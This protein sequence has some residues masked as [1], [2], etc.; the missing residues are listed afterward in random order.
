[1]K[2]W[3]LGLT[4]A[5]TLL[6]QQDLPSG[7]NCTFRNDP[8]EYLQRESRERAALFARTGKVAAARF[9]AGEST[10]ER[11]IN[12]RDV[13]RRNFIDVE[14]FDR[15]TK[16]GVAS[17][18]LT[19]DE[20]FVRRIY[21]DLTGRLPG[22]A[23]VKSFAD[24]SAADKRN[25][26]IDRLLYSPAFSERWTMWLGDLLGVTQQTTNVNLQIG[27]RNAMFD[28]L[29]IAV[30]TEK[31]LKDIA[32]A[33]VTGTGNGFSAGAANFVVLG[34]QSMGPNQ[35]WYDLTLYQTADKFLGL[36]HYDCLLCHDGRGHLDE[37]SM[38]GR[39]ATRNEA[40]R[41]AAF[42]SRVSM[43]QPY[44]ND[45]TS[46]LNGSWEVSDLPRGN[47]ALGSTFGNRPN[48]TIVGTQRSLDAEY[49]TGAKPNSENWRVEF[50]ENMVRD[51]LMG[52]NFAN[53]IW[54]AMFN[55][56]LVEPVNGLD[57]ARL[58]PDNPPQTLPWTLQAS[59]PKLLQLLGKELAARDFSLREFVRL[60]A[61]SSAYQLSARFDGEWNV[62]QVPLF[63]RHYP[64][65]LEAEEI[66]DAVAKST[67]VMTNYIPAGWSDT[68]Q[69]AVQLPDTSEP[70]AN[71]AALNFMAPFLRG[72][73]DAITRNQAGSI[74]QQL[75][76]MNNTFVTA[77]TKMNASPTLKAVAAIADNGGAVEELYLTVLA[78]R[79][80]AYEKSQAAAH[81]AKAPGRNAALEDLAWAL[82]NK[83]EFLFSY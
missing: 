62:S 83:A 38:W 59:H 5:G 27:G 12:A 30:A 10:P 60:I 47:Y 40:Q 79:P 1:M 16:E 14:I 76:L 36:S 69:W 6:A 35:D 51:P 7:E 46:P 48:R 73:R 18:R 55:Y 17:A 72:N 45:R 24:D 80:S 15:L 50:A 68:V 26:L 64:R 67:G 42:F 31:S 58:D 49:R 70:R 22:A 82:I 32:Y 39:R 37:L 44:N 54:R 65:R 75:N 43:A 2:V 71:G 33:A 81:F 34:R 21:L 8:D 41:M 63:A 66:H 61:E 74:L 9:A 28:W 3:L 25:S 11:M 23:E 20:E 77:K 19:T 52:I 56:G 4:M 53:R 29:R 13:P 78:R 57:P